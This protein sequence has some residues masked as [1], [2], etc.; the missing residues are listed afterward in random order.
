MTNFL[1]LYADYAR[2]IMAEALSYA[3]THNLSFRKEGVCM[4]P[5]IATYHPSSTDFVSPGFPFTAKYRPVSLLVRPSKD[6]IIVPI[7]SLGESGACNQLHA[8]VIEESTHL[9]TSHIR[10]DMSERSVGNDHS[11][12]SSS[13]WVLGDTA[14]A[15]VV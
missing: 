7:D 6:L 1:A 4:D 10:Q 13:P 8:R 3:Y 11:N 14:E 12:G 15:F 5:Q 2:F 9:G